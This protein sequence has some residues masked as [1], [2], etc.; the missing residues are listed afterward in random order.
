MQAAQAPAA[1]SVRTVLRAIFAEPRYRWAVRRTA[2]DIIR[3]FLNAVQ[4][5]LGR[6]ALQHPIAF[7]ALMITLALLVVLMFTHM[8]LTVR[9]AFQRGPEAPAPEAPPL[10]VARDAAW[11]LAQAR[12]LVAAERYAEALSHR[13]LA[14]VLELER[15]HV[16]TVRPSRTPAEYAREVRLDSDGRAGFSALVATLYGALF[17]RGHVDAAAFEA[18]DRSA[19]GLVEH[20]P[21]R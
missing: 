11:H 13:F 14:L 3:E 9:R 7:F 17:G 6:L 2:A 12:Q 15:R 16:V 1:D 20:A 8:A 5:F 10:P 4:D 21:V 18:F 19:A